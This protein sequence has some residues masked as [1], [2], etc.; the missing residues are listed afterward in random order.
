M[1]RATLFSCLILWASA[2]GCQSDSPAVPA[3]LS[4]TTPA[5]RDSAQP[6]LARAPDGTVVLSWQHRDGDTTELQ[7]ATYTDDGWS[8]A[9][10]AARG[11]N[12]FVN[13]AD[14]GSV[15]P[16]G[17]ERLAAHWLV[18]REGG[19][20]AY[21][22]AIAQSND[23]GTS[24]SQAVSPHDDGTPTEHGF[25]SLFAAQDGVGAIWL[26]GRHKSDDEHG[27]HH[28][29]GDMSL[30]SA[31]IAPAQTV[32]QSR[33]IDERVCDCCQTDIAQSAQGQVVVYRN[34]S[35]NETRDIYVS[36]LTANGWSPG[37]SV[38]DDGWIITGCP[39]NGPAIA[40]QGETVVVAWFSGANDLRRVH[41]A[42]SVNGGETF[43]APVILDAGNTLGRVDV[44]L[45][46][47]GDAVVSSL[48]DL[49][50]GAGQLRL[51]RI[52]PQ[53]RVSDVLV[54]AATSTTRAS[55]FAQILKHNDDLLLA[56]IENS[57]E[58]STVQ[59]GIIENAAQVLSSVLFSG[60]GH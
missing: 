9:R 12:W 15:V 13:W 16:L 56:W 29:A 23:G 10:T 20:Y 6:H 41:V 38:A 59:V 30:R 33:V 5:P 48:F 36:R 22:V 40:A 49:G 44:E 19:A 4:L 54:V 24:W 58:W 43:T 32:S 2:T 18:K 50:A 57:G 14:F 52:D 26:D 28:G 8:A 46:N 51:Q 47:N 34:R 53:S 45:L 7:F 3:T 42:R 55:G 17:G 25:V 60:T 21:D 37:V 11:D 1:R 31:M 39:V 27:A 35:T